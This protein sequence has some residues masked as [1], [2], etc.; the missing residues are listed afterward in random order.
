VPQ[1]GAGDTKCP[2]ANFSLIATLHI[3]VLLF[4]FIFSL[5]IE[6]YQLVCKH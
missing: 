5:K 4:V 6:N 2:F 1:V 3:A